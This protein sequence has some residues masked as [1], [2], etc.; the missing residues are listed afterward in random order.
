[1]APPLHQ[2]SHPSKATGAVTAMEM[3]GAAAEEESARSSWAF[4]AAVAGVAAAGL[5]GAGVLVWW[6]VVFHPATRQLWMVPVG[7]V[8][9]GTPL[10]AWLSLFA[11]SPACKG[12]RLGTHHDHPLPPP[13][14]STPTDR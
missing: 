2:G 11:S 14:M 8:L 5:A 6:A 9:L 13:A 1:M 10:L 3:G 12:R 4:R 7:L